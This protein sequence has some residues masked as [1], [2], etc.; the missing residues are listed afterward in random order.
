MGGVNGTRAPYAAGMS[1]DTT[2]RIQV[3]LDDDT[4]QGRYSNLM[5]LNHSETEFILD[6]LFV[7]PQQPTAKVRSRIITSPRHAKQLL[8]ALSENVRHYERKFGTIPVSVVPTDGNM[9]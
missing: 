4:A 5:M 8:M 3:Q 1:D 2:P 9:H 6:F 7:Q